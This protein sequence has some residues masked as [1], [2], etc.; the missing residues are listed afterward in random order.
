MGYFNLCRYCGYPLDVPAGT[1]QSGDTL[2]TCENDCLNDDDMALYQDELCDLVEQFDL[3]NESLLQPS[4][5]LPLKAKAIEIVDNNT[6][7]TYES[8]I[9]EYFAG[10]KGLVMSEPFLFRSYQVQNLLEFIE[11]LLQIKS[12]KLIR[13]NTKMQDENT[14]SPLNN[15]LPQLKNKLKNEFNI[16]FLIEYTDNIHD[17]KIKTDTGW[18]IHLGRGLDMYKK[19]WNLYKCERKKKK[20]IESKS[21][22]LK[23]CRETTITIVP[24]QTFQLSACC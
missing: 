5:N 23:R 1:D 15:I 18:L 7:H 13:L 9:G 20:H 8:L 17:R 19:D 3:K 16:D 24:V 2:Y 11:F 12:L 14:S 6:G 4:E 21:Y 10:C 22:K